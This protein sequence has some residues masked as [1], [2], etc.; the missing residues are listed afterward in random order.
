MFKK[1]GA[2]VAALGLCSLLGS[3]QDQGAQTQNAS[4]L[5]VVSGATVK[6][7]ECPEMKVYSKRAFEVIQRAVD[8]IAE[9]GIGQCPAGMVPG[10]S[11]FMDALTNGVSFEFGGAVYG[12][13][14]NDER[15]TNGAV[16]AQSTGTSSFVHL[17]VGVRI[18]TNWMR[19]TLANACVPANQSGRDDNIRLMV[20]GLMQKFVRSQCS[21][22]DRPAPWS[23][24]VAANSMR[25]TLDVDYGRIGIEAEKFG[26][27]CS[28]YGL[29]KEW[30]GYEIESLREQC[31]RDSSGQGCRGSDKGSPRDPVC[32]AAVGRSVTSN[33]PVEISINGGMSFNTS[34][35]SSS[36]EMTNSSSSSSSSSDLYAAVFL[37]HR[38]GSSNRIRMVSECAVPMLAGEDCT[39]VQPWRTH[40]IVNYFV[41]MMNSIL[42]AETMCPGSELPP[43]GAAAAAASIEA[44]SASSGSTDAILE[45]QRGPSR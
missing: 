26:S 1:L 8:R 38:F 20:M 35:Q 27:R 32:R 12:Y 43:V 2:S 21:W 25:G 9:E 34:G 17:G 5:G 42:A 3:C 36:G 31:V 33:D 18:H 4:S 41:P 14:S 28:T 45:Q 24:N 29:R 15:T 40:Y 22:V 10:S 11:P 6:T 30:V 39:C 13:S 44:Q 19:T 23:T 37:N 7:L 16:T